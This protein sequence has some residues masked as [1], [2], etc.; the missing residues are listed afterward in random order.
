MI[1]LWIEDIR[2]NSKGEKFFIGRSFSREHVVKAGDKMNVLYN[3]EP[4]DKDGKESLLTLYDV[5]LTIERLDRPNNYG[6]EIPH[7]HRGGFYL[8]GTGQDKIKKHMTLS[9]SV[10]FETSLYSSDLRSELTQMVTIGNSQNWDTFAEKWSLNKKNIIIDI[11]QCDTEKD[12][13]DTFASAFD[14]NL[15]SKNTLGNLYFEIADWLEKH[16]NNWKKIIVVGWQSFVDKHPVYSQKFLA[17][18]YDAYVRMLGF[19]MTQLNLK[20]TEYEKNNFEEINLYERPKFY[21]IMN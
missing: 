9:D 11:R 16:F 1:D 19:Y 4:T 5:S 18:L 10:P 6:D 21:L 2:F 14:I 15:P 17:S 20:G 13:T 7:G 12:F 8:K 3:S